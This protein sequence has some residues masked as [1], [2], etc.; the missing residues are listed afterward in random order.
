MLSHQRQFLLRL[1]IRDEHCWLSK[2]RGKLEA[3]ICHVTGEGPEAQRGAV[4]SLMSHSQWR[5]YNLASVQ[6]PVQP[7][8]R[9]H[10]WPSL[11]KSYLI[12][13]FLGR[14]FVFP[15]FL[16]VFSKPTVN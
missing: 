2:L 13:R 8:S 10:W 5:A 3:I 4:T 9:V 1:L 6:F 16:L 15:R 11:A 12:H 7:A 14:T